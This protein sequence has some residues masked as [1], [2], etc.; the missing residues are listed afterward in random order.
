MV[1]INPHRI[2]PWVGSDSH[3]G[4]AYGDYF[5]IFKTTDDSVDGILRAMRKGNLIGYG[6]LLP[7]KQFLVD[8]AIN[9]PI[10][11]KKELFYNN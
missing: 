7:I 1:K 8:G 2:T 4:Y 11:L 3:G 6:P 10:Q 5:N 9:Q